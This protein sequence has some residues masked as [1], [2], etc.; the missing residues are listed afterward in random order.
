[1]VICTLKD[2]KVKCA[3]DSSW[4]GQ[5]GKVVSEGPSEEV[6]FV[7]VLAMSQGMRNPSFRN[8]D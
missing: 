7:F 1:M 6:I 3:G 2:K 8:R 5:V 4:L